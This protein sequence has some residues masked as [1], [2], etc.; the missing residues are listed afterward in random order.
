MQVLGFLKVL[1]GPQFHF[2]QY[3]CSLCITSLERCIDSSLQS[4][5]WDYQITE[6]Y[7]IWIMCS[8]PQSFWCNFPTDRETK[9]K[10]W[11]QAP[12]FLKLHFLPNTGIWVLGKAPY[13][14]SFRSLCSGNKAFHSVQRC[15]SKS[16]IPFWKILKSI[17]WCN[18]VH[19]HFL[20]PHQ[21]H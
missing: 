18:D 12:L 11:T 4:L 19:P 3:G 20:L 6:V 5:K 7:A 17:F 14:R 1:S 8:D 9:V 10:C 2:Y 16:S 21:H 13:F 15:D